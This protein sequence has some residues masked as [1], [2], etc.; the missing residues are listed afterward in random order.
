PF[1]EAARLVELALG[2][3]AHLAPHPVGAYTQAA[4]RARAEQEDAQRARTAPPSRAERQAVF[5]QPPPAR[6][7]TAPEDLAQPGANLFIQGKTAWGSWGPA[8]L[9]NYRKTISFDWGLTTIPL[10]MG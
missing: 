1:A 7:P 9:A 5:D 4:G 3:A 8:T 2:A 6:P 10:G